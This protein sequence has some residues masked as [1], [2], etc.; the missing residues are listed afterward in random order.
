MEATGRLFLC[1]HCRTQVVVCSRCDRGQIDC[2][3]LRA[4]RTP[5]FPSRKPA[6][7]TKAAGEAAS[8][9]PKEPAVTGGASKR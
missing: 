6:A 3:W 9:M 8:S 4:G 5:R 1:H 7:A 2:R